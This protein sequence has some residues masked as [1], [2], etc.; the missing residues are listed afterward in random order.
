M[1][2]TTRPTV[3]DL[4]AEL[5][6]TEDVLR[7]HRRGATSTDQAV[8]HRQREIVVELRRRRRAHR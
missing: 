5:A 2:T 1:D 7:G 4:I 8:R 3:R 6:A